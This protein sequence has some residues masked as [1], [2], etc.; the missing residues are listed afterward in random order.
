M[1]LD[2]KTLIEILRKMD[3]SEKEL[4]EQIAQQEKKEAAKEENPKPSRG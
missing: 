3:Q 2:G 4:K 1:S